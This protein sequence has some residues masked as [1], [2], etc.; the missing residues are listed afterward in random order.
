MVAVSVSDRYNNYVY[1]LD[2]AIAGEGM[3]LGWK[4]FTTR[5]L[6]NGLLKVAYPSSVETDFGFYAAWPF[7]SSRTNWIEEVVECLREEE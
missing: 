3:A 4:K 5:P 1:L 6:K 7:S 2:A